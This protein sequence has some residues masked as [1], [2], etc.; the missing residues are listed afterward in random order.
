MTPVQSDK[1]AIGVLLR[2]MIAAGQISDPASP[3]GRLLAAAAKLFREKGYSRTTVRDLAAEVGIL[4]GS[5]FHHFANKDEI[6]FGVMREV[7]SAMNA[8]LAES[9]SHEHSPRDKV[10]ALIHHELTFVLGTPGN[11]SAVLVFEWRAL[12]EDRQAEI[13]KQ[14]EVY[15]QLWLETL[16]EARAA[17]LTHMESDVLRQL[18]HGAIAWTLNW[19]DPE[20]PLTMD[21][22]IERTMSLAV[23]KPA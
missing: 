17:G 1:G 19:Y 6:L 21:D 13:L 23:S 18:L 15:D 2:K 7:V 14:R 9:L 10:R 8:S 22:L 5:I 20:G 16:E 4:S 11:A 3:K 12:S